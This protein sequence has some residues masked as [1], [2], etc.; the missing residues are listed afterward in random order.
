[1]RGLRGRPRRPAPP[2]RRLR[3]GLLPLLGGRRPRLPRAAGRGFGGPARGP[4]RRSRRGR[5]PWRG[6]PR[7]CQVSPVL[8]LQLPQPA[9]LRRPQPRPP[10]SAA[11]G[12][13]D[14]ADQLGHPDA[15]RAPAAAARAPAAVGSARRVAGGPR[16]G[17]ARADHRRRSRAGAAVGA[18]GPPG[19]GALRLGP[20]AAGVGGGAGGR[21]R[22]D[23]GAARGRSAGR[24]AVPPRSPRRR[25]PDA[26]AAQVR[27]AP[28]RRARPAPGRR[29]GPR[30]G[31]VAGPPGRAGRR[32]RQHHDPALLAAAGAAGPAPGGLPRARGGVAGPAGAAPRRPGAAAARRPRRGQQPLH[33]GRPD[34]DPPGAGRPH[35]RRA[36][37]GGR[38]RRPGARPPRTRRAAAPAVRRPT[39]PPQRPRRRRRRTGRAG[40]PGCRRAAVAARVGVPRLRMVRGAAA[41]RRGRRRADRPGGAPRLPTRRRSGAG[42]RRRGARPLGAGRVLRQ[43]GGGGGPGRP[44]RRGQRPGWPP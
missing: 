44:A 26:G 41:C 27:A 1:V 29:D 9:G 24:R 14:A 6:A 25:L 35:G 19:R 38:A 42:G 12:A 18:R 43:H 17:A 11:L 10:R 30:A 36:Q 4:R 5:H 31:A 7:T 28:G 23:G 13:G 39:V 34:Q 22:R 40:H 20:G 33:P 32:V 3:R 16:P 37:P 2:D 21:G 8:P 15:R